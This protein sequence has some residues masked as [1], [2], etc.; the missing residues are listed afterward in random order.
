[1]RLDYHEQY[2]YN[3]DSSFPDIEWTQ[4]IK[5]K[6]FIMKPGERGRVVQTTSKYPIKYHPPTRSRDNLK[7]IYTLTYYQKVGNER[8]GPYTHTECKYYEISWCGD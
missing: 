5:D 7:L 2:D 6:N 8:K 4:W 1:M 3:G